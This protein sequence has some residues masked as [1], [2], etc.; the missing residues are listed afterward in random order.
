MLRCGQNE[1]IFSMDSRIMVTSAHIPLEDHEGLHELKVAPLYLGDD[2]MDKLPHIAVTLEED[3]RLW[4]EKRAESE[5]D[6]CRYEG[7]Y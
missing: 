7:S 5:S 6:I 2:R 3:S 4:W 1:V